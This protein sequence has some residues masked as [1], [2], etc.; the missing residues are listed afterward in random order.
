MTDKT[1]PLDFTA[2]LTG[3]QSYGRGYV[4]GVIYDDG[5]IVVDDHARERIDH[6]DQRVAEAARRDIIRAASDALDEAG[7]VYTLDRLTIRD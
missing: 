3:E 5:E 1:F 2:R 4:D 7:L 6:G